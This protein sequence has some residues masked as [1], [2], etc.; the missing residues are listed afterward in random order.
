[1]DIITPSRWEAFVDFLAHSGYESP[2]HVIYFHC[3]VC[4]CLEFYRLQETLE[5]DPADHPQIVRCFAL[6]CVRCGAREVS[7]VHTVLLGGRRR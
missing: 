2:P 3:E 5:S 7:V 4:G 6:E 1:V